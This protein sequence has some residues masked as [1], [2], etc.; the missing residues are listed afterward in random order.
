MSMLHSPLTETLP[1]AVMAGQ[2]HL[3]DVGLRVV[4]G[5]RDE[6]LIGSRSLQAR[7]LCVVSEAQTP[8]GLSASTASR[9]GSVPHLEAQLVGRLNVARNVATA[10][11]PRFADRQT[12]IVIGSH[13][14]SPVGRSIPYVA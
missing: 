13:S 14:T 8:G 3:L 5:A 12:A 4:G 6:H 1:Q 7:K 2:R 11:G 10:P 9:V